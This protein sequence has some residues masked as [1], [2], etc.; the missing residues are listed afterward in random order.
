MEGVHERVGAHGSHSQY[1]PN[2]VNRSSS[3]LMFSSIP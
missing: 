2:M 1:L 3:S